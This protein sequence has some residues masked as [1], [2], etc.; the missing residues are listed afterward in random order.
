MACIDGPFTGASLKYG[1]HPRLRTVTCGVR[2]DI[3]QS[4]AN[5]RRLEN[6]YIRGGKIEAVVAVSTEYG[7]GTGSRSRSM[8]IIH[9]E[10]LYR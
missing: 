1:V 5:V 7:F 4:V 2:G 8:Q 9:E 6:V 3:G 10:F